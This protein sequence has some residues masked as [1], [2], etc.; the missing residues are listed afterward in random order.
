[1]AL[2]AGIGADDHRYFVLERKDG[3]WWVR[4]AALLFGSPVEEHVAKLT[5]DHDAL[6]RA[7]SATGEPR[8]TH[9]EVVTFTT[10]GPEIVTLAAGL[11]P[12]DVC[13]PSALA[14]DRVIVRDTNADGADDVV[15]QLSDRGAAL[16]NSATRARLAE[17]CSRKEPFH[18]RAYGR[19]VA[20]TQLDGAFRAEPDAMALLGLAVA[21]PSPRSTAWELAPS[22]ER[23]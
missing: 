13:A 11:G 23:E 2:W 6:V 19:L 20:F 15:L 4:A 22:R 7:V 9:V 21:Q 8:R 10:R 3:R 18:V 16:E 14:L 17:A 12:F 5:S 1:M